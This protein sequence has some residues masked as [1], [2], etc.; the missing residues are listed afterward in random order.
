MK[1]F[2]VDDDPDILAL[3]ARVLEAAGHTVQSAASSREALQNIPQARPD[4]VITDI[5]MPEMDGF[6]LT[7][8]LRR[9]PELSAM[10]IIVL[11]MKSYEFDR[12]RAKQ[13][14][15][16]G[17]ITKPIR[18]ETLLETISGILSE[19]VVVSYWGVHGTLPVPGPKTLRYGGN[20]PCVTVEVGGEPLCIFDC[21]SGIKRLSDHLMAQ[22][23]QRI[24]ARI[25]ISH[26][27]WDHI[28]TIPF[29]VPLYA[30]GNQIEIHG[31]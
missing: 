17:Y 22:K 21:G 19:Q 23:A 10:K 8:E 28:N 7:R 25:F 5:M 16:D 15:A 20:T 24:T 2:L 30:R 1:F 6:E 27:H 14:G 29:F 12:R 26:P 3:L 9:R 13:L 31:P 11:S 18:R 4:C